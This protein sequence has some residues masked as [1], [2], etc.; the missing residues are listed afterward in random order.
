MKIAY[1]DC[2][3]GI[4][5]DMTVG[6]LLD[7]GVPL[8][9]LKGELSRL[10]L[11]HSDYQLALSHV[12]RK[13]I[14]G[15][16]FSVS[17]EKDQPHR[18]YSDIAAMIDRSTL[19]PAVKEKAQKVFLKLAEAEAMV[20]GVSIDHVHFHEVGA[21]DSIVD[22]VGT[23]IGLDYLKVDALHVSP[24]PLGGG[25]IRSAHGLLPVPA[26][27]TLELL[28]GLPIHNEISEGE[29]VTPTGAAIIKAL[30]SGHGAPAMTVETIG[31]GAGDRDFPDVPNILRIVLGETETKLLHDEVIVAET[32]IDDA[33]PEL[34]GHL[35][36]R[37]LEEG[38]FDAAFSPLQMKKNRP[39]TRLTLIAS[40]EKLQH[41]ARIVLLE[42][43]AIGLRYYPCSRLKLDR[44]VEQRET[45]LGTV[46]VKV[47]RDGGQIVRVAPEFEE[48]RRLAEATGL[49][50]QEVF[51]IVERDTTP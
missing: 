34:L 42:S 28:K 24:L 31:Y 8:D 25:S 5:G 39:A 43:A 47:I 32:H 16:K 45:S 35:M 15:S 3:A 14:S 17:V 50:L 11:P 37:L 44:S 10:S 36:E 20:H 51:R 29:R 41:L 19:S 22:I 49:P 4:S 7:L 1:F 38:A 46:Q 27:A 6:A 33:S 48:C 9:Y 2:F 18:H 12:S 23:A 40:P 21:V 13:G 26:P 30:A